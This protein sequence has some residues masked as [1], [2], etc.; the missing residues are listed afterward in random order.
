MTNDENDDFYS[1]NF[2]ELPGNS[3]FPDLKRDGFYEDFG[4]EE[5]NNNYSD[6]DINIENVKK[7]RTEHS[8][9][10]KYR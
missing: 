9:R 6:M 4:N 2:D 8:S 5:M 1:G 10:T 3:N 7:I